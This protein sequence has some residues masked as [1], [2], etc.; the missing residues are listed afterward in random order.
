MKILEAQ[1]RPAVADDAWLLAAVIRPADAAELLACSCPPPLESIQGS[2]ASS[3]V[4]FAVELDGELACIGGV[5]V[6]APISWV[7]LLTGAAVDR[8]RKAFWIES[9]RVLGV[10]LKQYKV[11]TSRI[12]SRYEESLRWAKRLGAEVHPASVLPG[13]RVPFH[14]VVWRLS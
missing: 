8:H 12:D 9:Q 11:L 14:Q 4:T 1:T 10:L 7:W 6:M 13:E 5:Q 2:M 3:A